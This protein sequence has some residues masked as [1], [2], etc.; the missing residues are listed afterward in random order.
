MADK[1]VMA[2]A[3]SKL[4]RSY[5]V[6]GGDDT[7]AGLRAGYATHAAHPHIPDG[8]NPGRAG[9]TVGHGH[10]LGYSTPQEIDDVYGPVGPNGPRQEIFTREQRERLKAFAGKRAYTAA[11]KKAALTA[12][13]DITMTYEQ[14]VEVFEKELLVRKG[15]KPARDA[16]PGFDALPP[17]QQAAIV[18]RTYMRGNGPN[19]TEGKLGAKL[20]TELKDAI[21]T[22]NTLRVHAV[23]KKMEALHKKSPL[24]SSTQG[25]ARKRSDM[26]FKGYMS[27]QETGVVPWS[28]IG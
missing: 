5:E 7:D 26:A 25:R 15:V 4:I 9:L 13:R 17:L 19:P 3:A 22:R 8:G 14:A 23:L 21:M 18:D 2:E 24:S 20:W 10:D 6:A 12:T 11:E 27:E 1:E 28:P 16:Y